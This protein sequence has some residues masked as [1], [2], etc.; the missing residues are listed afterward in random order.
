MPSLSVGA[1]AFVPRR[2]RELIYPP[3]HTRALSLHS[4]ARSFTQPVYWYFYQDAPRARPRENEVASARDRGQMCGSDLVSLERHRAAC[5]RSG[6]LRTRALGPEKTLARICREAGATV[7]C[8]AKLR[9][10]DIAVSAQDER[11]IEVLG[12]P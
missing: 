1:P 11:A 8:N 3:V 4:P 9:D 7:R 12:A 5:P 6:R 2:T 10:M